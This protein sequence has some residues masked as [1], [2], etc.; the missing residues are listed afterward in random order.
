[1]E[2]KKKRYPSHH[3]SWDN[4]IQKAEH[5]KLRRDRAKARTDPAFL[6]KHKLGLKREMLED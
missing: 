4:E 2:S 5:Q 1:M 6:A 3:F